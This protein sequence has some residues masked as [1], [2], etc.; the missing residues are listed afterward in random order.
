MDSDREILLT[1]NNLEKLNRE[2]NP[3]S[4]NIS[5]LVDNNKYL[6]PNVKLHP[7]LARKENTFQP[8]CIEI[9]KHHCIGLTDKKYLS[10][11]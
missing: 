5:Y 7:L 8:Q 11:Q 6:C 9:F 1:M 2:S 4:E 3:T 10:G